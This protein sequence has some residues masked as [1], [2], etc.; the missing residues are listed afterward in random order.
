MATLHV[1]GN[2]F[3]RF[4]NL[5]TSYWCFHEWLLKNGHNGFVE[6]LEW[7]FSDWLQDGQNLLWRD[8]EKALGSCDMEESFRDCTQSSEEIKD[9][10]SRYLTSINDTITVNFVNP[11][12][13]DMPQLFMQW[14]QSINEEILGRQPITEINPALKEF[15]PEGLFLTF[16]YTETLEHLYGI[17]SENICHIH[18]RVAQDE[19]PIVGHNTQFK[20]DEPIEMTLGEREEKKAMENTLNGLKKQHNTNIRNNRYF[21]NQI[22][23]DIDTIVVYGHSVG[24]ID[25][26]Y[27]RYIKNHV[28]PEATWWI[29]YLTEQDY[30][31]VKTLHKKLKLKREQVIPFFM[32]DCKKDIPEFKGEVEEKINNC[33][34]KL[35]VYC[36]QFDKGD[37][38]ALYSACTILRWLLSD[39]KGTT[40]L[41]TQAGLKE[42]KKFVDSSIKNRMGFSY[43]QIGDGVSGI[44]MQSTPATYAGLLRKK[45]SKVNDKILQCDI[46]PLLDKSA[47][48]STKLS[49]DEWYHQEV[50]A[51]AKRGCSISRKDIIENLPEN[52][53]GV[54][55]DGQYNLFK[56]STMLG[57]YINGV[58][59]RF[60]QNPAFVSLRQIAW[61]VLTGMKKNSMKSNNIIIQQMN[62][63]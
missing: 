29:S 32:K 60:T 50:Y 48:E 58:P 31:N 30:E 57:F 27:F 63:I 22:N 1:I 62:S 44:N 51:N 56:D 42:T 34:D 6:S 13:H 11:L 40:S 53:I 33:L 28:N 46:A 47:H 45:L 8:F 15:D 59:V 7:F 4:H 55:K 35:N 49:F 17:P 61:E 10:L 9:E 12:R 52:E 54:R 41:L 36:E 3:D 21:F 2:G 24:D 39:T 16:N 20:M 37:N 14:V 5:P 25:M 23:Q 18:N 19:T 26:P 38:D 43:W